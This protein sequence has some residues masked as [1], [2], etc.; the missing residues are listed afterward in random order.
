VH[1]YE[2]VTTAPTCTEKGYTTYT[3]D[4]GN[5]YVDSY[6]EATG[7]SWSDWENI[8]ENER[9]RSCTVCGETER[10]TVSLVY[11]D[12]NGDDT[13]NALDLILLRQYLAGW[14]VTIDDAADANGDGTANALD[15]ILL[16]QYLAGWD[17]TLGP[18]NP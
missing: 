15:L 5:E 1:H 6:V 3:C 4:C 7:H 12:A 8:S 13:V 16:R 10:E 18:K 14:D 17:V 2:T 9:Q 11:G